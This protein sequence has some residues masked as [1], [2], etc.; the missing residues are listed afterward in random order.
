M[1]DYLLRMTALW[2]KRKC[3]IMFISSR[4]LYLYVSIKRFVCCSLQCGYMY[5]LVQ[6][7]ALLLLYV[8][9]M[10]CV[11]NQPQRALP[12]RSG[13]YIEEVY[14]WAA[15][16]KRSRMWRRRRRWEYYWKKASIIILYL[17]YKNYR[18]SHRDNIVS[19]FI[20]NIYRA[21]FQTVVR[22]FNAF[23]CCCC[24]LLMRI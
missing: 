13:E 1:S 24:C 22:H 9:Q 10:L 15:T 7:P 20:I 8:Y 18:G 4:P 11:M 12:K 19:P 16:R 21:L 6:Y 17:L 23:I 3:G 2:Q 14:I 5:L